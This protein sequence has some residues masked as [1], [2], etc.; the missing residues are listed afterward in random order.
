MKK[1][2][3]L[4]LAVLLLVVS[5]APAQALTSLNDHATARISKAY[6]VYSGP[7]EHYYRA[8]SGKALFGGSSSVRIYGV[9]GEWVLMGYGLS[10]GNYR[11][12]YISSDC[13]NY[14]SNLKGNIK[15]NLSFS[16]DPMYTTQAAGIS[17]DPVVTGSFYDDVPANTQV[18]GL[19]T[20][21]VWTYVEL[22]LKGQWMRGFIQ[23][24]YL[25]YSGTPAVTA[26][27]A[28]TSNPSYPVVTAPPAEQTGNSQ[29]L[30]LTHN[31]P[32]TGIMLPSTFSSHQTHY[33]LTVAD[34]VTK[35]TFTVV[36]MD[37]NA[38][39]VVN[40]Q[41]LRSGQTYSGIS[42]TDEPQAVVIRVTS[43]SSTT[44]YTVYLQRRP[45]EK[46]TRVSA[47]YVT[48]VYQ[49]NGEWRLAAD[50]GTI[51]YLSDNYT[52]G[53]RSTFTNKTSDSYD[54]KISPN[55][56]LYYGTPTNPL[57]L[58]TVYEFSA[59]YSAFGSTL[60]TIVYIED[61]IVAVIPYGADTATY[62]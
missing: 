25:A 23:T 8:N 10:N 3:A 62:Y 28:A 11:V 13:L 41:V 52:T 55:C 60:Y 37:P 7:G 18:T 1:L 45:S 54:Y 43:A 38:T 58:N 26:P 42:M 33:L 22:Q 53:S 2:S 15:Y 24:K 49:K 40:G 48:R 21:G 56:M 14:V 16:S 19:G 46:R 36:A 61:E 47:G 27:P 34:W 5:I 35:P 9:V 50:L 51:S 29:L 59:Y 6:P 31:C 30:A 32:N 57:R 12:G 39:I 20:M 4:L 17:D 44:T